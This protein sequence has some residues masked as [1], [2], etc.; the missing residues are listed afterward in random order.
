MVLLP[1]PQ[2]GDSWL[3]VCKL[4]HKQSGKFYNTRTALLSN[5]PHIVRQLIL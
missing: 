4:Y 3:K 5:R 2:R 1:I